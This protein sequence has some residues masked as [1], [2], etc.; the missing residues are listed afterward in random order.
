VGADQIEKRRPKRDVDR[1]FLRVF[2]IPTRQFLETQAAR[3]P[4]PGDPDQIGVKV[5]RVGE[6]RAHAQ[7]IALQI[8]D[9]LKRVSPDLARG[10]IVFGVPRRER[11]VQNR[12]DLG[13]G[14]FREFALKQLVDRR[15]RQVVTN[16]VFAGEPVGVEMMLNRRGDRQTLALSLQ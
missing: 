13:Q 14:T 10:L 5:C 1:A 7:I 15:F 4:V 11:D 2:G 9:G 3:R 16:Q 8:V 6:Q 12:F